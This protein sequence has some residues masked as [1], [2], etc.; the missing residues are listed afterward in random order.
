MSMAQSKD[1]GP[2]DPVSHV[3]TRLGALNGLHAISR[4]RGSWGFSEVSVE[5]AVGFLREWEAAVLF[6]KYLWGAALPT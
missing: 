1:P 5:D 4:R 6:L 3:K 2:E